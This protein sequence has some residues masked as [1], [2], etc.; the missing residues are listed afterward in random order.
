MQ[1]RK[2]RALDDGAPGPSR[3]LLGAGGRA[4]GGRGGA[5]GGAG[6]AGSSHSSPSRRLPHTP[7]AGGP[8]R[9]AEG[10]GGRR[11]GTS[12]E[13]RRFSS[14]GKVGKGRQRG[15]CWQL[16]GLES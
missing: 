2:S 10:P 16:Y 14:Q 6:P 1:P 7:P 5:A 13:T 8:W 3:Q 11:W 9:L 15:A 12:H 4:G